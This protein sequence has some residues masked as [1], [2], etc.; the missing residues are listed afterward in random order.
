MYFIASILLLTETTMSSSNGRLVPRQWFLF[1]TVG[2]QGSLE[3]CRVQI[4]GKEDR[5]GLGYLFRLR[6]QEIYLRLLESCPKD[7]GAIWNGLLGQPKRRKKYQRKS[8]TQWIK[9]YQIYRKYLSSYGT[10]TMKENSSVNFGGCWGNH[11]LFCK[12]TNRG[13]EASVCPAFSIQIVFRRN[14]TVVPGLL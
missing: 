12:L 11:L 1:P 4:W 9:T 7:T 3:R 14:L 8:Q 6:K 13:E 10:N 5:M 2:N